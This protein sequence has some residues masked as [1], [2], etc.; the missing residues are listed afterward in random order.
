MDYININRELWNKKTEAHLG[1]EFYDLDGFIRGNSS[2]NEI[3]LR[4]LGNVTGK[5]I[6][7]LQ[8]HFGQDSISLSRLGAKVT[9]VDLSDRSIEAARDLAA[10]TKTDTKFVCCDVYNAP[11]HIHE[12]F[13]IVYTSYG[14]IGWLP[15]IDKWARVISHFLKPGGKLVFVEFHPV[16]WMMDYDFSKI[17]YNYF[18]AGEIVETESVTYADKNAPI[19]LQSVS[20][21]HGLGE[22]I[23][24]LVN[25]EMEINTLEEYDYSPY[26]CFKH[27]VEFEPKKYRVKH[28]E[29][30]LPM[31]YA[32]SATRK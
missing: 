12:K 2:L 16:V 8:C 32:V 27:L 15:D 19:N 20:W 4:L 11:D 6:L 13:D 28:L 18:N 14:T 30:K 24:A 5:S 22:V 1:S 21:N 17:E 26:D 7:H 10:K 9:G 25:A 23:T 31:V 29:N 3:E